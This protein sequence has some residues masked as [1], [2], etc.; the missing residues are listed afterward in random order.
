M[1][2]PV[3]RKVRKMLP[4]VKEVREYVGRTWPMT[5]VSAGNV[6]GG[7]CAAAVYATVWHARGWEWEGTTAGCVV[8]WVVLAQALGREIVSCSWD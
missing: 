6:N 3:W 5:M 8:F 4:E 7:L 1:L 2:L